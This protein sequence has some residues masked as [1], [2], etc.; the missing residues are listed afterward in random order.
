MCEYSITNLICLYSC[1]FIST[2]YLMFCEKNICKIFFSCVLTVVLIV[3][4]GGAVFLLRK[5]LIFQMRY[6]GKTVISELYM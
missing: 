6:R 4:I 3:K 2:T 5:L 1:I